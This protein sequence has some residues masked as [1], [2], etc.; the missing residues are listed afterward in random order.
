VQ[1]IRGV[2]GGSLC[3]KSS[4]IWDR[5]PVHHAIVALGGVVTEFDGSPIDYK[6]AITQG[7]GVMDRKF[8][9][10]AAVN[11]ALHQGLQTIIH[12]N[13]HLWENL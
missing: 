3:Y 5:A 6:S 1:M 11:P 9:V 10:C 8:G 2:Y 13:R 12:A 7:I 4:K